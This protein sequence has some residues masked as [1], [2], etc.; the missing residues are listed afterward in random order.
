MDGPRECHTERNKSDT[1]GEIFCDIP[2]MQNLKRHDSN[3]L[4]YKKTNR[5]TDLEN[6]LMVTRGE[7]WG[8]R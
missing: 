5:L 1:E 4:I 3:E 2:Y 7:G 6:K 8:K